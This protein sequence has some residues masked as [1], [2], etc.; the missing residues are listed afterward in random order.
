M[1]V[2][3][4]MASLLGQDIASAYDAALGQARAFLPP[5]APTAASSQ[6]TRRENDRH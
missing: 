4:S 2:K 5:A 1:V 6:H 3:I